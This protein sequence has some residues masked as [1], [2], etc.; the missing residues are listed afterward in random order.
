MLNTFSAYNRDHINIPPPPVN[1]GLYTG[2]PFKG[3]W[4]N[5][6]IVPD[7]VYL[8]RKALKLSDIPPPEAA[9]NQFGDIYRPGNSEPNMFKNDYIPSQIAC[10]FRR[11]QKS[12][13]LSYK[14]FNPS[15]DNFLHI[16]T[17][18]NM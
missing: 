9:L 7:V 11:P 12:N 18:A 3:P 2:E 10:P 16:G 14:S 4:G 17:P 8:T 1:G 15:A 5:V 13:T 6:D